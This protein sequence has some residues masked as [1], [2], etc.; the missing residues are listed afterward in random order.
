MTFS[1]ASADDHV[2]VEW[3]RSG[4][5]GR[6][7]SRLTEIWMNETSVYVKGSRI[8]S[9]ERY[10]LQKRWRLSL[11]KKRYVEEPLAVAVEQKSVKDTVA[12]QRA[13][14]NYDPEYDWSVKE[15]QR[16]EVIGD[17]RC[18]LIVADGDA[19]YASESVELWVTENVPIN[20]VLFNERVTARTVDFDW[21]GLLKLSPAL[22][23]CFVVKSIDMR[24]PSIA[25]SSTSEIKVTKLET[26]APPPKI[27]EVPEGFQ[28]VNSIEEVIK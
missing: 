21:Q 10:D 22:K 14:W 24:D 13:G 18:K 5:G 16:E 2:I 6:Y 8:V 11:E 1:A 9:I 26:A 12:I 3:T 7:P 4:M 19:D 15:T 20:I 25:P 27:Y 17:Q 23:K 28:K